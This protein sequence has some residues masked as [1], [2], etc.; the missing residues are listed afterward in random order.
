MSNASDRPLRNAS[1]RPFRNASERP[2]RN[3][4]ERPFRND[5]S[6]DR[7]RRTT[8][9][10]A[11]EIIVPHR[12]DAGPM[13]AVRN[14]IIQSSLAQLK[15][16]GYYDRYVKLI[17]PLALG[18]LEAAI[19]PGWVS[20]E[21]ATAH[22]RAC[23]N[24]RLTAQEFSTMGERVGERVQET[25]LVTTSRKA[26]EADFDVWAAT[27]Q[28]NRMWPRLFQGGSVQVV[29][30]GPKDKLLEERGMSLNCFE[31]YRQAHVAAVRTTYAS[32]PIRNVVARVVSYD[33]KDDEMVVRVTWV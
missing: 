5:P 8:P 31:Y 28:L 14:V 9:A 15:V 2:F 23:E 22:Y 4:S 26:R 21:L 20:V 32:L 30:I 19:S 25:A 24:L 29:K 3:A 7:D 11:R 27:P 33:A 6:P 16:A 17:D 13:T 18:E 12:L 10:E 1:E